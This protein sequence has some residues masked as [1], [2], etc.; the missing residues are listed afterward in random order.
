MTHRRLVS[1]AILITLIAAPA[2]PQVSFSRLAN[3]AE[4]PDAWLTYSGNYNFSLSFA[5]KY[6][7]STGTANV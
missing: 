3:A 7:C 2:L 6:D 1:A 4:D 5:H